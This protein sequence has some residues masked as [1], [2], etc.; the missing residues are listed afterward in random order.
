MLTL[1]LLSALS[2]NYARGE[3]EAPTFEFVRR[4][5]EKEL[6]QDMRVFNTWWKEVIE[7]QL[8]IDAQNA[9]YHAIWGMVLSR[10]QYAHE[11]GVRQGIKL[12]HEAFST[13][14]TLD[15]IE[16]RARY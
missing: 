10:S 15:D 3:D 16:R 1:R 6:E 2:T 8:D 5:T 9:A 12:M 14:P 4:S 11:N 13:V 7:K